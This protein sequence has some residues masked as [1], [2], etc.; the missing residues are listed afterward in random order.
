MPKPL[1]VPEA[2]WRRLTVQTLTDFLC[3]PAKFLALRRLGLRLPVAA[4]VLEEREAFD[5]AGVDRYKL[6]EELLGMKLAG[7]S[8]K[9]SCEPVRA[10]GRLPP[11]ISG[12]AHFAQVRRDVEVFHQRL[13][14]FKPDS[15]RPAVPVELAVGEFIVNGTVDHLTTDGLLF[16]RPAAIKAK[17]LLRAWVE[18]L[19]WSA[20]RSDGSPAH[21]IIVGRDSI[22]RF[23]AAADP[24]AVLQGLLDHYWSGLVQ[25]LSFFPESSFA[26][27]AADN[28]L[29]N[30]TKG[31]RSKTP[32]DYAREKWEGNEFGALGECEDEYFA[33]FFRNRQALD[34]DFEAHAR[35]VFQPLLQVAEETKA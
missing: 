2:A 4:G 34:S 18:H 13:G 6:Q 14:P 30:G 3:H 22:W 16:Y 21:A 26:F 7:L 23:A 11:G 15:L 29:L 12:D 5:V 1:A 8:L 33:L 35:A 17:D 20:T 19:L 31:N 28:K 9:A 27:A 32:L 25:P 24:V 10:S